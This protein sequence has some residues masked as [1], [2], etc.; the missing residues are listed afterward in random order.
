MT[1]SSPLLSRRYAQALLDASSDLNL[2]VEEIQSVLRTAV[3]VLE[4]ER[5]LRPVLEEAR[6]PAEAR[7]ALIST[8]CGGAANDH[9]VARLVSLLAQ[10]GRLGLLPEIERA[11]TRLWHLRDH[12]LSAE[13]ITAVPLSPAQTETLRGAIAQASGKRVEITTGVDAGIVGGL[14][15]RIGGRV[16]DGSVRARLKAL[17]AALRQ[18]V[19]AY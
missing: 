8:L 10:R 1:R 5:N 14:M 19:S 3:Q 12:I 4:A 13:A 11:F 18:S 7:R 9:L 16:F 2:G 15:L 17:R 6:V